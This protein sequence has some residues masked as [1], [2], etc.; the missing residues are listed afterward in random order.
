MRHLV[1]PLIL[2]TAVGTLPIVA[3]DKVIDLSKPVIESVKPDRLYWPFDD[4]ELGLSR[5]NPT[6]DQSGNSLNGALQ[7]EKTAL[8]PDYVTGKYGTAISIEGTPTQSPCVGWRP[9]SPDSPSVEKLNLGKTSFTMGAWIKLGESE[10]GERAHVVFFQ[11]PAW[12]FALIKT[13]DDQWVPTL[14]SQKRAKGPAI[15]GLQDGNW[16]HLAMSV[17]NDAEGTGA[18]IT[19]WHDGQVLGTPQRLEASIPPEVALRFRMTLGRSNIK[20]A[21]VFDDAFITS[22]VYSFK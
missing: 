22:G 19:F 6:A 9:S 5:P 20:G 4:G 18:M 14:V 1:I 16:H 7:G 12:H 2:S 15:L 11:T 3:Q 17:E 13:G 10:P 21:T 8:T